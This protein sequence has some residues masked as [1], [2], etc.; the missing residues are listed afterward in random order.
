MVPMLKRAA[1]PIITGK[2]VGCV[3]VQL[4]SSLISIVVFCIA[5]EPS[6]IRFCKLSCYCLK[7]VIDKLLSGWY[8]MSYPTTLSGIV[9]FI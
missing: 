9:I 2:I 1:H 3:T 8:F 7:S 4:Y 5:Y 6:F